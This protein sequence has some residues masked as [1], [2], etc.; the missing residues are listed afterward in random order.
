MNAIECVVTEIKRR[1]IK[2]ITFLIIFSVIYTTIMIGLN[3]RATVSSAK[4]QILDI[5]GAYYEISLLE[6]AEADSENHSEIIEKM[7][8]IAHVKGINKQKVE[9]ALAVDFQV[10]K[11]YEGEKPD[12]DPDLYSDTVGLTPMSVVLDA[13]LDC[14]LLKDFRIGDSTLIFG[15][16]PQEGHSEVMIEQHLAESND[17]SIGDEITLGYFDKRQTC[18]VVGMYQTKGTFYISKDNNVG[19]AVFAWSP[20]NRIYASIDVAKELYD[21]ELNE[22]PID[23][24]VDNLKNMKGVGDSIQA[25]EWD[26]DKYV[27]YDMTA[28]EYRYHDLA[29]QLET[30]SNYASAIVCYAII[31]GIV[32]ISLVLSL[33]LQ[34]FVKEAGIFIALGSGKGRVVLQHLIATGILSLF[35]IGVSVI[36]SNI[37]SKYFIHVLIAKTTVQWSTVSSFENGMDHTVEIV[38]CGMGCYEWTMFFAGIITVLLMSSIPLWVKLIKLQPRSIL[39]R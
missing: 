18:K 17:L 36:L 32:L 30:V 3:M 24:Y 5:I 21:L 6:D 9:Y 13:N 4:E 20:Y 10:V 37:L 34:Y 35:S 19:E 33:L 39:M 38:P 7:K 31:I 1:P 8:D 29:S 26:W 23:I 15:S 25:L 14:S 16:F 12:S 11:D 27:L 22:M 2:Y 28:T